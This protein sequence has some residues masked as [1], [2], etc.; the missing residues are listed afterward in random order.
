[1]RTWTIDQFEFEDPQSEEM[2]EVAIASRGRFPFPSVAEFVAAAVGQDAARSLLDAIPFDERMCNGMVRE[3][4]D[5]FTGTPLPSPCE[6]PTHVLSDEWNEC[7]II[8]SAPEK[9]ISYCWST[10]A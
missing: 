4:L 10:S 7:H 5:Q 6:W 3:Y 8:L 1:M 2:L 9:F